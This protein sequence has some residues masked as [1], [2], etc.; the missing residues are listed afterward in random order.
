M[1][2]VKILKDKLLNYFICILFCF[3][4]LLGKNKSS[5]LCSSVLSRIGPVTKFNTIAKININLVLPKLCKEEVENIL[6]NMW[7]NIGRN[8]GE[9]IFLKDYDP[10]SCKNTKIKGLNKLKNTIKKSRK[11][12]KGII[13]FSAHYSNWEIAPIVLKKLG[14]DIL[15]IYRKS[16]NI[17]IDE[18]IQK[19]RNNFA[20][21]A[22][23][24]DI[25]AKKSFLWLRNGKCL[26]LLMDQKLNEGKLINFL[27]RPSRTAS[28]AAE[29]AMRMDLDLVP[30]KILR[31]NKNY[32]EI[33][34]EDSIKIIKNSDSREDI[35]INLLKKINRI[36]SSWICEHPEQWLWVH[37]RWEKEIYL[38]RNKNIF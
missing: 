26:A 32:Y 31:N 19:I 30:V 25:G 37:R 38:K 33:T 34:F 10:F 6:K 7:K 28:A 35:V 8:I 4:K 36:L 24:G 17:Y 1:I 23:K 21:Y 18:T 12:K 29:L 3:L 16:N 22:P 27:G 5:A 15:C 13:F 11:N 14:L 2:N 20:S 9:F